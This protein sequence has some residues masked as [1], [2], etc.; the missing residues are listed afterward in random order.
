MSDRLLIQIVG[1]YRA[2]TINGVH[3]NIQ[4]ARDYGIQILK[5]GHYVFIP[6][7]MTAYM[8]G[9]IS[10]KIFLEMA[11]HFLTF[12]DAIFTL[13]HWFESKESLIEIEEAKRLKLKI[14]DSLHQIERVRIDE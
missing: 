13:P 14:Y 2:D 9:V 6:H 11:L 5:L 3:Q 4:T 12:A 8:N 10:E 7:T 1:A